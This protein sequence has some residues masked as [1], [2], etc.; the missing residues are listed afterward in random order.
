MKI[1]LT[2]SQIS[3]IIKSQ[4]IGEGI[5][6]KDKKSLEYSGEKIIDTIDI[7]PYTSILVKNK[8]GRYQ[9]GLT[10]HD[11]AFTN[12]ISQ[13]KK[14][15]KE[16]MKTIMSLWGGLTD[17]IKEWVATYGEIYGGSL[18]HDKTIKYRNIFV[19]YGLKCGEI[20]KTQGGTFFIIYP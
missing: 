18:N 3:K 5:N 7:G 19:R 11:K 6:P 8:L 15:T 17:K 1:K 10:S 4:E 2:E 14:A 9:I 20:D 13:D 16:D 12:K